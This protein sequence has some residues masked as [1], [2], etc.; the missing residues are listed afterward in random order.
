MNTI[1]TLLTI[2]LV[3]VFFGA[4]IFLHELG[5]FIAAR[6]CRVRVLEF[7]LG[8]GP[9]LLKFTSKKTGTVYSL[10]L[11]P[12]GGFC[13]MLGEDED[14]TIK[15][16]PE[17]FCNRPRYQRLII[18]LAGA[19]MN[20]LSAFLAMCALLTMNTTAIST[21]VS[22]F[23]IPSYAA[24]LEVGDVITHVNETQ[25]QTEEELFSA[26]ESLKNDT[27]SFTV[28]RTSED[29]AT[30]TVTLPEVGL[31][32]YRKDGE[33]YRMADFRVSGEAG[34]E[35]EVIS[36]YAA[37]A[38]AGLRSG[39]LVTHINGQKISVYSDA[40]WEIALAADNACSL[41]VLRTNEDGEEETVT[42][43]DIVF[44]VSSE[45]GVVMGN[46]DFGFEERTIEG[47]FDLIGTAFS[48]CVSTGKIVYR[49]LIQLIAGRFGTAAVS[50]PIGIASTIAEY[51]S[52]G[53]EPLL[54]LFALISINLGLCNLLPLPAL[55]GGR[56]LFVLV[57][58]IR[59]KPLHRKYEALIH[60]AGLVLLLAFT[61]FV[62]VMDVI[63]LIGG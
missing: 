63:R 8:M 56:L 48:E 33:F 15:E 18:L 16:N 38:V 59:R 46:I 22:G 12:I 4:M 21:R 47:P 50:G 53:L 10:R 57:E 58:M 45:D 44:P 37:S 2:L 54:N 39:D 14:D 43:N 31:P 36:Y 25:V 7:A 51:A 42:L 52:Y 60:A 19:G 6:L 62:A 61:G 5:H 20:L 1:S 26:I 40:S 13:A 3:I 30:S 17:A 11:F 41:T 34:R 29:G 9:K 55:D 32:Q 28:L 49:S 27:V 35:T 24:G 23:Y